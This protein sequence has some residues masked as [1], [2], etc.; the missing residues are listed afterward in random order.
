MPYQD[1]SNL[2][3]QDEEKEENPDDEEVKIPDANADDSEEDEE[4]E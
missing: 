1:D 3:A 4:A 2:Y